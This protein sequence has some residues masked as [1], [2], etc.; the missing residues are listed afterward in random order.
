MYFM[1]KVQVIL[2]KKEKFGSKFRM[3]L[4]KISAKIA[5][6][7]YHITD[8]NSGLNLYVIL[9]YTKNII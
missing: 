3:S 7:H 8:S 9:E 1:T 2:I 6:K 4:W 5:Q